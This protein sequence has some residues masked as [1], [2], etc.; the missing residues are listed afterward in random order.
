[1]IISRSPLRISLGGGASDI[2]SYYS[3][4]GGFFISAAIQQYVYTTVTR[5]N[6]DKFLLRYSKIENVDN[7]EE[8]QHP[9]IREA[10]K[11]TGISEP[12]EIT[13]MADLPSGS[14]LGSSGSFATAL[15]KALYKFKR[16]SI[17]PEQLAKMA[18]HI[19]ID[20][21]KEPVGLQDQTIAAFGGVNSFTVDYDGKVTVQPLNVSEYI[22]NQLEENLIMVSTGF[23]RAASKVLKE[24]DDKTKAMDQNMIDNLHHIKDLGYRS[25]DALESCDLIEFGTIM[26]EHWQYK[27]KRSKNMSNPDIDEWYQI[28]MENG[29]IGGKLV[30]AGLGGFLLFYTEEKTRLQNAFKQ[31]GLKEVEIRFDFEGTKIL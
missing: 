8:I 28:A 10:L 20:L 9:I 14:G 22:L 21:L 11:L 26:H 30:G 7:I 18:C 29:A 15:L 3:Q 17:S 24:Q 2:A 19:E 31:I 25:L 6:S 13:S 5:S 12:L 16:Q 23:Y 27:K 1:M 4:Y